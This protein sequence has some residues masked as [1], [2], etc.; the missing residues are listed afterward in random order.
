MQTRWPSAYSYRKII[1]GEELRE[2]HFSLLRDALVGDLVP[3]QDAPRGRPR[4]ARE[5]KGIFVLLA[6]FVQLE[7]KKDN[8]TK[9]H[10]N[11][12]RL[13]QGQR[14]DYKQQSQVTIPDGVYTDG[15]EG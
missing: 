15:G 3:C 12:D 13:D 2:E 14:N 6:P 8:G 11:Q 7:R 1:S 5:P 10:N 4:L 9:T